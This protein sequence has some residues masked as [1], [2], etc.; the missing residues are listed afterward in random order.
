MLTLEQRQA[1]A[2][3]YLCVRPG[4]ISF[5]NEPEEQLWYAYGVFGVGEICAC[6][7][8]PFDALEDLVA[9]I[10]ADFDPQWGMECEPGGLSDVS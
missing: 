5:S 2:F 7:G 10:R 4:Q 9:K 3:R 1:R 6:S 8:S